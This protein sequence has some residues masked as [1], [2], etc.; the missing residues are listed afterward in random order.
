MRLKK[1]TLLFSR[2]LLHFFGFKDLPSLFNLDIS[3]NQVEQMPALRNLP[4]LRELKLPS[5]KLQGELIVEKML[6]LNTLLVNK[7]N[8]TNV[9]L[10]DLPKLESLDV[11]S[12]SLQGAFDMKMFSKFTECAPLQ[13]HMFSSSD[14][15]CSSSN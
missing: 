1:S 11:S 6:E 7:N 8:L 10:L 14:Q 15:N 2:T 13:A 4:S 9:T 5:N 12:N 3:R